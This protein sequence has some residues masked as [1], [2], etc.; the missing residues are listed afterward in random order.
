MKRWIGIIFAVF[1]ILLL[2]VLVGGYFYL[3]P[4]FKVATGYTAKVVCSNHYLTGQS[5]E[6]AMAELPDNPLVPFL[7]VSLDDEKQE[8][9]A[10]LWGWAAKQKAI[11]RPGL[12]CTLLAGK[13]PFVTESATLP[14]PK[15]LDT[16]QP[17][18]AGEAVE[19]DPNP[20][21]E[22]VLDDAFTDPDPANPRRTR[23]IVVVKDG[24]IIAERY[25]DGYDRDTPFLGWSMTKSVTHALLGILVK[26]GKLDIHQPAPVPEWGSPDDPRHAITTDQLMRMSSGL[27][28]NEDYADLSTGVTQML[29][30]TTDMAAYAANMPLVADPDTVWNYSSGTANILSRIIRDLVGG[31]VTDYWAFPQTALFHPIGIDSAVMEPDASGT[32]VGSSY[33]YATAR[34]WARFGLLYL[35]GGV[36]NGERILPEGW[37]DYARTPT[38]PSQGEYGALWWL[39]RGQVDHKEWE[40][41]PDDAYAAEGHDGQY[42]VVIP[43]RGM[44]IVRLG[45]SRNGAWDEAAFLRDVLAAVP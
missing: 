42:V 30:N 13:G 45:V 27:E 28:F 31:D 17:W 9:S 40:G 6:T 14:P 19:Y 36:W 41:V 33:M 15:P 8:L 44:V 2:V 18:P 26:Q 11:Y 12:G 5:I 20:A 1:I 25:A 22:A 16:A 24:Q 4:T 39:N 23:A 21:L 3:L 38:P 10:T 32:L 37:V 34:D 29:Y 43:S 35:N 7:R